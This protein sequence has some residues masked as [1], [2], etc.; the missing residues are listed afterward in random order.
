MEGDVEISKWW[1]RALERDA[2][3]LKTGSAHR[4]CSL[5]CIDWRSGQP[6]VEITRVQDTE[7]LE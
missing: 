5:G 1:Q 2:F 4:C 3:V 7:N 6:V